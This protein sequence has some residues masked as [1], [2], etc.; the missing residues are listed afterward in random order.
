MKQCSK[1]SEYKPEDAFYIRNKETG[2]LYSQ[3]IHCMRAKDKESYKA[4]RTDR[5]EKSK[6]WIRDNYENHLQNA[7]RYNSRHSTARAFRAK[8]FRESSPEKIR[9]RNAVGYA[10]RSGKLTK[11]DRC[12]N[13]G[14]IGSV[15]GHHHD[16][17]KPLDVRW[18]CTLCHMRLHKSD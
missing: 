1:C 8:L 16:Y 15:E 6:Q 11:P 5:I 13:C 2:A 12:Q 14:K 10:V 17:S 4:N 18:I 3:C 9:A 7:R